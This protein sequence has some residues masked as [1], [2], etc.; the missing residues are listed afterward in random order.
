MALVA[1]P[2]VLLLLFVLVARWRRRRLPRDP[3]SLCVGFLHPDLGIG[4]AE[5][6]VVDAAVATQRR[7]HRVVIYTAH[8]DPSR[9]F[10]ETRDGTLRVVVAGGFVPRAICGR[11]HIVCA[12]L[13]PSFDA[14]ECRSG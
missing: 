13:T 12:S 11:L 7:G 6:L 1:V 2:A 14:G 3:S 10:E 8:H 5:R 9:C 4:G